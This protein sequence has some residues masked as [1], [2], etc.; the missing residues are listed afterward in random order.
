MEKPTSTEACLSNVRVIMLIT[1]V[2]THGR[3][4]L[5]G[6]D[7]TYPYTRVPAARHAWGLWPCPIVLSNKGCRIPRSR[8]LVKPIQYWKLMGGATGCSI[9]SQAGD[10]SKIFTAHVYH[11][12]EK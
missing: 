1:R 10:G 7:G 12:E 9:P 8:H 3:V 5:L 2:H 11:K 6:S 4:A